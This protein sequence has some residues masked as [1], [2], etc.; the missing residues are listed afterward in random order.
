MTAVGWLQSRI[1][2]ACLESALFIHTRHSH[3]CRHVEMT[4]TG[5]GQWRKAAHKS[6]VYCVHRGMAN[7][8][9]ESGDSFFD[10]GHGSTESI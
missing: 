5:S 7:W 10:G 9:E 6:Q 3:L 2:K 1:K 4:T 8:L